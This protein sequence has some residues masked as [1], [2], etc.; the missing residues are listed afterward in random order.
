MLTSGGQTARQGSASQMP[1]SHA[2][3]PGGFELAVVNAWSLQAGFAGREA[4]QARL[5]ARAA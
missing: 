5:L 4:L 2:M 3:P 1:A